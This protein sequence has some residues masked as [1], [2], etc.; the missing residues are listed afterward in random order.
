MSL[1]DRFD[2][3]LKAA[4]TAKDAEKTSVIR[5][6]KSALKYSAIEKKVEKLPDADIL[7]IIQKQI[8]Q[9]RESIDQFTKGKRADLA[10]K[11]AA[12]LA[13]LETYLPKQVTGEELVKIVQAEVQVLGASSK[14]DFGRVMKSLNEKLAGQ[15]DAKSISEALNKLLP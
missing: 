14:K 5:F 6:L 1:Y 10:K 7:Q 13:I 4:M 11:E 15:A 2:A 12:E 3:D 9:R 8:K